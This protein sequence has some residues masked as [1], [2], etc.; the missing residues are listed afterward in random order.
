[1]T[2]THRR[3]MAVA[4]AVTMVA[5]TACGSDSSGGGDGENAI[6]E[7][8][9]EISGTV[10]F[11]HAYSADSPEVTTITEVLIPAF[12]EEHP[13]VDVQAVAVPYN[14]LHQKLVTAVAGD[15]LPDLVRSDIIWVPQLAHLGVLVPLDEQMPDFEDYA[16]QMYEGPL[17]TNKWRDHYYGLPLDTNTRVLMYNADTLAQGGIDAP[18]ATVDELREAADALAGTGVYVFADNSTAGWNVLPWIWS[19]GGA[20]TDDD[21]T[22]A[23]GYL[24]GAGSVA[25]VQLLVDL[26]QA[27]AIPDLILGGEGGTATSDGLPAGQYATI[28]DGPWMFPI[29][30]SQYPDF[31]LLTAPV[32]AGDGGS[33]SVVGGESIVLTESSTNKAAAAEFLRFLLSESSQLAMAE[34]GQMPVLAALG[35]QLAEIQDYYPVFVEQLQTARPRTPTPAWP[36]MEEVLKTQVQLAL[37]GE[38]TAQEAMDGA[39]EQIDGLLAQY[40]D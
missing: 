38:L 1:M 17:A 3:A 2:R 23:T 25:G 16:A 24:N 22:V 7:P 15:A 14:D 39:A 28:L 21:V 34:V 10:T 36:Q 31:E 27:G 5:L 12:E 18:P 32:P 40:S 11:W 8:G 33:V 35:D 9:E 19:S 6:G 4:T 13:G 29:F 30:E 37:R 20:V 26:Y